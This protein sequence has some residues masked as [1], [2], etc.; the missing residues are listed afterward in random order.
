MSVGKLILSFVL[1]TSLLTFVG[2]LVSLAQRLSPSQQ[3]IFAVTSSGRPY[4][5]K[6]P[7][8]WTACGVP[9]EV[10]PEIRKGFKYWNDVAGRTLFT[11]VPCLSIS[12]LDGIVV[13]YSPLRE[14]ASDGTVGLARRWFG[15]DTTMVG[16]IILLSYGWAEEKSPIRLTTVMHEVGHLLGFEHNKNS[17]CL[18]SEYIDSRKYTKKMCPDEQEI[19]DR[20][21]SP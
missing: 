13:L 18:M 14:L 1:I 6:V 10:I 16:G 20:V 15:E 8:T 4:R 7:T 12:P 2:V 5:L 17:E 9:A 21:Y 19:F 11:E 3:Q